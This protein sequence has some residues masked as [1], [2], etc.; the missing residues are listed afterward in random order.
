MWRCFA[1][2][3]FL[4]Y[5]SNQAYDASRVDVSKV[6]DDNDD[7]NEKLIYNVASKTVGVRMQRAVDP[8]VAA[9]LDESDLSHF[10]SDVED[11]DEDF[12]IKANLPEE[13]FDEQVDEKLKLVKTTELKMIATNDLCGKGNIREVDGNFEE[14]PR[15]R[16]AIDEQFD[17]VR[18][19]FMTI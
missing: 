8:E 7:S 1:E 5:D 12:V 14:K 10:G 16:R 2:L 19:F 17:M 13:S 9:M 15:V 4:F 18:V 3:K 6:V 11:L